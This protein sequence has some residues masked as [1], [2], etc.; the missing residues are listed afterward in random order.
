MS[1]GWRPNVPFGEGTYDGDPVGEVALFIEHVLALLMAL[2]DHAELSVKVVD[3][4][5]RGSQ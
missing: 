5:E 4:F 2:E 3:G 1:E